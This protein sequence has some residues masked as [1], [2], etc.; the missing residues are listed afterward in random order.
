MKYFIHRNQ[1]NDVVNRIVYF[2]HCEINRGQIFFTKECFTSEDRDCNLFISPNARI[3]CT[4]NVTIDAWTMIGHGTVILTHDHYHYGRK[5]LLLLQEEKGINWSNL[6]IGKDVW[7]HNCT[8]LNQVSKIPDGVVV[9]V[10]STLTKN[11][12]P[13]EIWAGSP[14][15]KIGNRL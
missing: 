1:L 8:V 3:D 9:G 2:P 14:A 10:N 6:S 11:P 13:Y 15:K 4:G 7:L 5:P 12:G